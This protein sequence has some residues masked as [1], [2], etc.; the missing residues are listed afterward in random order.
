MKKKRGLNIHIHLTNR[1]LYTLIAIG[2]LAAIGIGVYAYGTANPAVFG[3]SYNELQPCSGTQ[4]LKMNGAG[5]WACGTDTTGGHGDGTNCAAGQYPLGVDANGNAQSCTADALGITTET[6]PQVGV[7]TAYRWCIGDGSAVQCNQIPLNK[8]MAIYQLNDG[9][10]GPSSIINSG[11]I[12]PSS[13]CVS[14]N[15]VSSTCS[16]CYQSCG[17]PDCYHCT[18]CSFTTPRTCNNDL[19]GYLVY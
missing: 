1:W 3:H 17:N 14:A 19:M 13:T 12:V 15:C 11:D 4:I 16:N 8:G 18:S 10:K 2:I 7:V 5:A 9:C 6:D